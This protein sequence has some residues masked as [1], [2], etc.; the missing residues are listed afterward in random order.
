M[1]FSSEIQAIR[2]HID[3]S[4]V[5]LRTQIAEQNTRQLLFYLGLIRCATE[6]RCIVNAIILSNIAIFRMV[7]EFARQA[8]RLLATPGFDEPAVLEDVFGRRMPIHTQLIT[9]WKV[10]SLDSHLKFHC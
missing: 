6:I 2:M 3:Q 8:T 10:L 9:S 1:V 4:S 7:L 5:D